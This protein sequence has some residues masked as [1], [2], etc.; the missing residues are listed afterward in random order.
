[1]NATCTILVMALG[2]LFAAADGAKA[3]QRLAEAPAAVRQTV[4]GHSRG[5]VLD[6]FDTITIDG[7]TIYIAEVEL[8]AELKI[9]IAENGSLLRTREEIEFSSA[10]EAVRGAATALG[11]CIDG[12]KL[13]ISGRTTVYL[14]E[15]D[16]PGRPDLDVT[17]SPDGTIL[18]RHEETDD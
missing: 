11:G 3:K 7:K 6:E 12:I 13:E 15:I 5:G 2:T 4:S 1:M 17:L 9:Y 16:R 18:S 10:P 8:P 14:I